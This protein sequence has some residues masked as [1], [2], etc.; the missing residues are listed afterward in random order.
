VGNTFKKRPRRRAGAKST[1]ILGRTLGYPIRAAGSVFG[2]TDPAT[3]E[4][5]Y[6]VQV[7][8]KADQCGT[9]GP[10]LATAGRNRPPLN[11]SGSL[12]CPTLPLRSPP[13]SQSLSRA[14]WPSPYR[15]AS[16]FDVVDRKARAILGSSV[17]PF[18]NARVGRDRCCASEIS[19]LG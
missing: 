3:R 5:R 17:S 13:V 14:V 12:E 19:G 2:R 4:I 15:A 7:I 8:Q 6:L 10:K 11:S 16:S 9:L 1:R 18:H